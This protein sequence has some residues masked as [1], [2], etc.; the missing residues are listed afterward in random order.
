LPDRSVTRSPAGSIRTIDSVSTARSGSGSAS[1]VFVPPS[2]E[3]PRHLRLAFTFGQECSHTVAYARHHGRY[4]S[5]FQ[6]CQSDPTQQYGQLEA[7]DVF[8]RFGGRICE[9]NWGKAYEHK[10]FII[11][12]FFSVIFS[13]DGF[14]LGNWI[15]SHILF[16]SIRDVVHL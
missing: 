15:P 12:I 1:T 7:D 5:L 11:A 6:R 2:G 3:L 8:G 4:A 9:A 13:S 16:C 14:R 10:V